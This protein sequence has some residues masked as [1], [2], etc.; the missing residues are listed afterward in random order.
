MSWHSAAAGT[1]GVHFVGRQRSPAD[2]RVSYKEG[3]LSV[4]RI[5]SDGRVQAPPSQVV[6]TPPKAHCILP[7]RSGEVV[8]ATTVEGNAI[9]IFRIDVKRGELLPADMPSVPCRPG[10]GARHLALH[11]FLDVLYCVNEL[12]GTL[13]VFA[14]EPSTG[15]LRELQYA[16]LL[17]AGF[18]GN[19]RAADVHVTANG[20]FVYASVRSTDVIAGFRIDPQSGL[21]S[22]IGL[23]AAEDS[24][25]GFAVDPLDR[26]LICAGQNQNTVGVYAIDADSGALA[27]RHRTSVGENPNW[28]E[29][30]G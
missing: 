23:F 26:F 21:L 13:A 25:R 14:I 5:S 24:P 1:D 15:A 6:M 12:G 22:P 8:Y 2:G 11:P 3:M 20:H 27:L 9:L 7:G 17:P 30:Y 28:V 29:T 4:S 18:E 19:A 16:T 10:S